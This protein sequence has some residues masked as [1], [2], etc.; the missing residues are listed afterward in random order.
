[1]TM[2]L[3]YVDTETTGIETPDCGIIQIAGI[4][5]IDGQVREDFN[6]KCRPYENDVI[7]QEALDIHGITLEEIQ[8][9]HMD[10]LE[11][12]KKLTAI[13]SRYVDR[14]DKKDKFQIVAY[15]ARFD[16][17]HLRAWFHKAKDK[18]FGSWFWHPP[19]D[20]MGVCAATMIKTRPRLENFKLGT[21]CKHHG[22]PVA[23]EEQHDAVYDVS[24]TRTLWRKL[25]KW[26]KA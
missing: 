8:G 1:M 15:N 17:D 19:I 9:Y 4:I 23:E 7:S 14:Y 10:G 16:A 26:D 2:K 6:I 3:M 25:A 13:L 21:V 20:V 12:H 18:Y 22:I 11:A 24:I 5:E